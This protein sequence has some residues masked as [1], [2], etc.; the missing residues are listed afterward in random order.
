MQDRSLAAIGYL[1]LGVFVFSL[2]DPLIKALADAYPVTQAM[3]VRSVVALPILFALVWA[4]SG[5][6]ALRSRRAGLLALRAVLSFGAY[7]SYYLSIAALPLAEAV[8]LFFVAPLMISLL[9]ILMLGERLNLPTLI[10]LL[11]GLVGVLVMVQPGAAVFEWASLLTLLS[12]ALYGSAQVLARKLGD[13][14]AAPV[15]TFYQNAAFLLGAP[16]LAGFLG[17]VGFGDA[18][19]ASLAFLVRPW[20]WPTLGDFALMASCGVIASAGM[21]LLSQAYRL[22]PAAKVA[23]FEYT[24]ILW[25][26]L[27]GYLYFAEVPRLTTGFG[28]LFI[29]AA[30]LVALREDARRE[31]AQQPAT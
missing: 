14:E 5:A 26:P 30:G 28:A 19:H 6:A 31:R 23:V 17:L 1:C 2:Q 21:T 25:A 16:A 7:M 13:S 29:V 12:A 22:A 10:A 15:I 4:S 9:A 27:W 20:V 24:A 11:V 18:G 8:A 3:T